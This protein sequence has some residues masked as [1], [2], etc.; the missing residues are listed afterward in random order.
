ME[1]R[2]VQDLEGLEGEWNPGVWPAVLRGTWATVKPGDKR[3]FSLHTTALW[4]WT[5][6]FSRWKSETSLAVLMD[7]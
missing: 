4:L 3:V 7:L 1:G 6:R 5:L 2:A